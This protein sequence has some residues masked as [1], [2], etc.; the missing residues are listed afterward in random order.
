[1]DEFELDECFQNKGRLI[2]AENQLIEY[3][4]LL[5]DLLNSINTELDDKESKLSKEDILNNLKSYL[6]EFIK[7]NKIKLY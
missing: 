1:M 7:Y 3:K 2:D 4:E 5:I 6:K